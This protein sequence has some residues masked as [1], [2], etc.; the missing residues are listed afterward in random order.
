MPR[1]LIESL[2]N[3][4]VLFTNSMPGCSLT[5]SNNNGFLN[6]ST[7]DVLNKII[8]MKKKEVNKYSENSR[9]LFERVYSDIVNYPEFYK[10]IK[11]ND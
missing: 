10:I 3:G 4:L 2:S 1:F 5:V 9:V 11:N 6:F 7:D 8:K